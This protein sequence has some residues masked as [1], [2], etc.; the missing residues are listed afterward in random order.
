MTTMHPGFVRTNCATPSGPTDRNTRQLRS[1]LRGI[2]IDHGHD[3]ETAVRKSSVVGERLAEVACTG[4]DDRSRSGE[5]KFAA[6]LKDQ[7]VDVVADPTRSIRSEEAEILSDLRGVDTG[8]LSKPDRGNGSDLLQ[9]VQNAQVHGQARHCGF[10]NN[11][12]HEQRLSFFTNAQSRR[13]FGRYHRDP[14]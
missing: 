13:G 1:D 4:N 8:Q 10:R 2:D 3:V 6:H 14:S 5:P 12:S 7:I 9:L 11:P